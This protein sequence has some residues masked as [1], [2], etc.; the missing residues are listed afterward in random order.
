[1]STLPVL[2]AVSLAALTLLLPLAPSL[3]VTVPPDNVVSVTVTVLLPAARLIV[4][5][6]LTPPRL[7]LPALVSANVFVPLPPVSVSLPTAAADTLTLSFS[8]PP[9]KLSVPDPALYVSV[10]ALLAAVSLAALTVLPQQFSMRRARNGLVL[11]YAGAR[12]TES[13]LQQVAD[14]VVSSHRT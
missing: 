13:D 5:N 6:L 2:A 3:I 14:L 11:W 8:N 10:L 1:M 4:A 7:A 12:L 9:V